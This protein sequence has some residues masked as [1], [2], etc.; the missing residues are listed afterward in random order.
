MFTLGHDESPSSASS[1]LV[2]GP[3]LAV[4]S[5]SE[6]PRHP[7]HSGPTGTSSWHCHWQP[8]IIIRLMSASATASGTVYTFISNPP[9][10]G[11]K[12]RRDFF[13]PY[14]PFKAHF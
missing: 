14:T 2:M 3:R 9:L 5:R 8:L 6:S 4:L 13:S 11:P 7:S 1:Y 12:A 10:A